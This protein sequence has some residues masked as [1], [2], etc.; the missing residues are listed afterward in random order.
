MIDEVRK[1][2]VF[3]A[4]IF[5]ST[6]MF[7]CTRP[8]FAKLALVVAVLAGIISF[9]L[10]PSPRAQYQ[11]PEQSQY[12]SPEQSPEQ[13]IRSLAAAIDQTTLT[14]RERLGLRLF[15]DSNL[16]APAGVACASCHDPRRAFTGN[17]SKISRLPRNLIM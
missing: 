2:L 15:F 14:P 6:L 7:R 4:R 13:F 9:L 3:G 11:S 8:R 5:A 1:L 17:N 16:S 12:Q 10:A